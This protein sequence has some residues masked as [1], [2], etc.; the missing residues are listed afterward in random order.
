MQ[1]HRRGVDWIWSIEGLRKTAQNTI[2]AIV[3]AGFLRLRFMDPS[4]LDERGTSRST[5][6]KNGED[7]TL[8]RHTE[9]VEIPLTARLDETARP[10]SE[11]IAISGSSPLLDPPMTGKE[12]VGELG[13]KSSPGTVPVLCPP[14]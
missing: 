1:K 6:T 9:T 14:G 2:Q 8:E 10:S 11:N 4:M 12:Q 13:G 5:T 3:Q 7:E